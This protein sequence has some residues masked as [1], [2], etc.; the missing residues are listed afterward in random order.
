[1]EF[2]EKG[3]QKALSVSVT[4]GNKRWL[5]C[6]GLLLLTLLIG[7][8]LKAAAETSG[9]VLFISSYHPGFPTF[10]QQ[11]EGIK[12]VFSSHSIVLDIEFM[13]SKRF[14]DN[15]SLDNFHGS[16]SYKLSKTPPYD[17]VMTADDNAL[18]FVL[19]PTTTLS[20]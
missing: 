17:L 3:K 20:R 14:Y 2:V 5:V 4:A 15:I 19:N 11:T 1:M 16:L 8:P 18:S 7:G 13:D 10:F 6:V 9:R 12:S